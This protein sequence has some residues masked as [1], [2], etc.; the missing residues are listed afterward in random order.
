VK[1]L[2]NLASIYEES[3]RKDDAEPWH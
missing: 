1:A 2:R 3:G